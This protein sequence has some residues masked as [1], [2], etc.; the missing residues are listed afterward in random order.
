MGPEICFLIES[1]WFWGGM[2]K[3]NKAKH[4]EKAVLASI[5]PC[6][7]VVSDTYFNMNASFQYVVGMIIKASVGLRE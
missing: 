5:S 3:Q 7:H 4:L 6:A 2:E 1:V